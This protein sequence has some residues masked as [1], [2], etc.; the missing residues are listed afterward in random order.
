MQTRDHLAWDRASLHFDSL[1]W[2]E[3]MPPPSAKNFLFLLSSAFQENRT[4]FHPRHLTLVCVWNNIRRHGRNVF[5][6][7]TTRWPRQCL[8]L[9][10]IQVFWFEDPY[11][12][13]D[14]DLIIR[15]L[16]LFF[17]DLDDSSEELE[18]EIVDGK[19]PYEAVAISYGETFTA[20]WNNVVRKKGGTPI[21]N[22]GFWDNLRSRP[23]TCWDP[24]KLILAKRFPK[25]EQDI[26]GSL[27]LEI[28]RTSYL[29]DPRFVET[30]LV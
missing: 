23:H 4:R 28:P 9:E 1:Q 7:S 15:S 30:T 17:I 2:E 26:S 14:S 10:F 21:P 19:I 29:R 12:D 25:F 16:S 11:D 6:P 24:Y 8:P 5:D 22:D 27:L 18:E 3:T 20:S 13:R